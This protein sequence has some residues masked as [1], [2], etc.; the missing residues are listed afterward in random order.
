MVASMGGI[1][2]LL[3]SGQE[4]T[5]RLFAAAL[6]NSGLVGLVVGL[7][8]WSRYGGKDPYFI[9]GVS[10]LAGLGGASSLDMLLQFARKKLGL[11]PVGPASC[12]ATNDDN[13]S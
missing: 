5:T 11:P 1:A 10:A 7:T 2:S 3:R 9:F 4:I 12:E 8:M 13:I 6:L